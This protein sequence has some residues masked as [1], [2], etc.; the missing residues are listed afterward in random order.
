MKI[1]HVIPSVSTIRG[2]PSQAVLEMVWALR[3]Q[4]VDAEIVTTNDAGDHLLDVPLAQLVDY[5]IN[6]H[7][8]DRTVPV[9]FFPRFSPKLTAIREFAFSLGFTHWLWQNIAD[10]NCL[11]VHAIFSYTSTI[12]MKIARMRRVPYI[13]RPLGQLCHWSLAQSATKKQLY[14]DW[15]ERANLKQAQVVHFTADS[16][17]QEAQA[18]LEIKNCL[19]LPHGLNVPKIHQQAKSELEQWLNLPVE[20]PI[21]LFL[22]RLHPKKGLTSLINALGNLTAS[23][24]QFVIAGSGDASYEQQIHQELKTA[25]LIERTHLVGFVEGDRKQ[26]LL[27]GAD[28]FVLPSHSENFGIA[29][30]EAMAAGLPSLITPEVG[31]AAIVR[32]QH[33]GWVVPQEVSAIAA[34]IANFLAHPAQ[35]RI[36]GARARTIVSTQFSWE[37]VAQRLIQQYEQI[38]STNPAFI[39]QPSHA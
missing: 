33:L 6:A 10:Y 21:I 29:V 23:P 8:S 17:W 3:Q 18:T 9:R 1:L 36:M 24:F 32:E 28:L 16:E 2:G 5:P 37:Q 19:I 14:L 27:Q 15:I 25:N 38:L 11:H 39:H 12:A 22:S 31:L 35:G 20:Q 30:L 7:I 13:V 4:G 34:T 26:I